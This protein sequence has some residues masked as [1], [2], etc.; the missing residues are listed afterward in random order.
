[1]CINFSVSD[2]NWPIPHF[3][4]HEKFTKTE[5]CTYSDNLSFFKRG[6]IFVEKSAKS[7]GKTN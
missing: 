4:I 2:I 1:M 7:E 3:I 6:N 5:I